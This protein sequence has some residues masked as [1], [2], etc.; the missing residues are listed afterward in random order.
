M[1]VD[2]FVL[3]AIYILSCVS[4]VIGLYALWELESIKQKLK[5]KNSIPHY[6]PPKKVSKNNNIWK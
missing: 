2:G 3:L 5:K 1:Y 6:T 4:V